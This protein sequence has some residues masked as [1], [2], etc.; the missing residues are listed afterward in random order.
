MATKAKDYAESLKKV[1][2]YPQVEGLIERKGVLGRMYN[3]LRGAL[4]D[5]RNWLRE[6]NAWISK[7]DRA[8]GPEV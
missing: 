4:G 5:I 8:L 2:K 6:N 1:T 7:V 3:V